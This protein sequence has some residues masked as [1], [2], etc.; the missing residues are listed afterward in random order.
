MLLFPGYFDVTL[1]RS[2][3]AMKSSRVGFPVAQMTHFKINWITKGIFTHNTCHRTTEWLPPF[4]VPLPIKYTN[5][6]VTGIVRRLTIL[7]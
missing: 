7:S 5:L 1:I 6:T 2:Q 3:D 4:D